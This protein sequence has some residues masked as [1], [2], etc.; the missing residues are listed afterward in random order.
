MLSGWRLRCT[1]KKPDPGLP[2][3]H[4][5]RGK[6]NV[7][8]CVFH[9]KDFG[10]QNPVRAKG[11]VAR[12]FAST[13][14]PRPELGFE[15][16]PIFIHQADRGDC[17]PAKQRSQKSDVVKGLFRIGIKDVVALQRL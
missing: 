4:W 15:P 16:L 8:L 14:R 13:H 10:F 17:G 6:P 1:G 5:V 11:D 3:H 2:S 7:R 9:D 12:G